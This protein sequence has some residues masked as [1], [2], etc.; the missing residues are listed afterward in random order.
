MCKGNK[1]AR[2]RAASVEVDLNRR[3]MASANGHCA[4]LRAAKFRYW[5][6][7]DAQTEQLYGKIGI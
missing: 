7:A 1:L 5:I 4:A 6:I 2:T 3:P